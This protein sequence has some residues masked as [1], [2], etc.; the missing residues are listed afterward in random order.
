FIAGLNDSK[1]LTAKQREQL[2]EE[3]KEKAIAWS[4]Q[5]VSPVYIDRYNI[6][7]ATFQAMRQAIEKL[8]MKPEHVL[9]DGVS[10]PNIDLP[11]TSIVKG[12]SKCASIAAASVLAKVARDRLMEEYDT[13]YPEYGFKQHKGYP[14]AD[15]LDAIA[16]YGPCPIH[17]KT[18]RGVKEYIR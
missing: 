5:V 14:T 6:L 7:Q 4:V 13:L 3:I 16:R 9:V 2:E 8:D 18:F 15:H 1:K 11:Q 10:I 17:R 12:D